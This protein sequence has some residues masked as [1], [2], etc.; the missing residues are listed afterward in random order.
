MISELFVKI[1][2]CIVTANISK[3]HKG[4]AI[5]KNLISNFYSFLMIDNSHEEDDEEFV[6]SYES[7]SDRILGKLAIAGVVFLLAIS[8]IAAI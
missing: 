5:M 6:Y 1:V 8:C 7:T 3:I 2:M 4:E